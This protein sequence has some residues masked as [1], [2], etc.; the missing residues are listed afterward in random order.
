MAEGSDS[1]S[2]AI[3]LINST[4]SG[5][6]TSGNFAN[7]GGI[8]AR[9]GAVTLTNSTLSGNSTSGRSADGGGINIL[10]GSVSLY[11]ST[12]T[13]N[14]TTGRFAA[15]GG[16]RAG[17]AAVTLTNSM[18]SGNSTS[19]DTASGGGISN[20]YGNVSLYSSTLN[21]NSTTGSGAFGGGI[22]TRSG[23]VSL[24]NSTLSGNS[25]S[26]AY[27]DGGAIR[28][29]LHPTQ[30]FGG[31]VTL[32]NS[33][34]SGNVS[35]GDGGGIRARG[36]VSLTNS[37]VSGNVS[38]RDGGG[39]H[40]LGAS[41]LLV[42]STVTGNSAAGLGG[43]I[44][45]IPD[46]TDDATRL[47]L[48]NSIVAGNTDNGAA[49]NVLAVD[50]LTNDLIVEN[51][52]IDDTTGSGI[53]AATGTGNI[54]NQLAFLGPLA[55]NG[56]STLTHALLPGSPAI[57][58]GNNLLAL[59]GNGTPLTTDQRGDARVESD[60]VDIGAVEGS[61]LLGDANLDSVV[62]FLDISPFINLLSSGSFLNQADINRDGAVTFLDINLFISLLSSNSSTA[63]SQSFVASQVTPEVAPVLVFQPPTTASL[64][65]AV[66]T[67][68][69][70]KSLLLKNNETMAPA[71]QPNV[72]A[73][74]TLQ[75]PPLVFISDLLSLPVTEK[76]ERFVV[77]TTVT[78]TTVVDTF[79]GPVATTPVANRF[80]GDRDSSFRSF[81]NNGPL[82]L[83]SS[84]KGNT[85]RLEFRRESRD[86]HRSAS[87]SIE[88][89]ISTAA[90]LF[91]TQPNLLVEV[92]DFQFEETLAG[93]IH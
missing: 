73:T 9:S 1:G 81:L 42:N 38:S 63:T 62:N 24:T 85:E 5:N 41:V 47:T 60:T 14:S 77:D 28:T 75:Q 59:D 6:S 44:G 80:V 93:L 21:G 37:T 79:I 33:T 67:P 50:D 61:F 72:D 57:D 89:S 87:V 7:G 12:L 31:V 10:N 32:N 45:L 25:A 74:E 84:L 29:G 69:D 56:G 16:I 88:N 65:A 49:P 48:H 91:D 39:I 55:D 20:T 68:I 36:N 90:E 27:S 34:V 30:L 83:R 76:S 4:L 8:H 86:E 26:G 92:F 35:G 3:S 52:L 13:G 78:E 66:K 64:D 18:L 82:V 11:S 23:S 53:S 40:T 46:F 17:S 19:G 43:A 15:G 71:A 70:T 2:G 22:F 58:T 51:S 54:L